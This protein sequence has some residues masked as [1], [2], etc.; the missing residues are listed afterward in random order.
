MGINLKL[1][2]PIGESTNN[3]EIGGLGKWQKIKK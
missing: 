1:V 3:N 2:S